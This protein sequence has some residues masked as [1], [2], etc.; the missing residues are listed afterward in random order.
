M[1]ESTTVD[2]ISGVSS[3][4]STVSPAL[5]STQYLEGC[6]ELESLTLRWYHTGT[7]AIQSSSVYT[8]HTQRLVQ[9]LG[10][11]FTHSLSGKRGGSK[12]LCN[13]NPRVGLIQKKRWPSLAPP[14][15]YLRI[16]SFVKWRGWAG[17]AVTGTA[18]GC[19]PALLLSLWL[20]PFVISGPAH[21]PC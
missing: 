16:S 14:S 17:S 1:P 7:I 19:N 5:S 20:C 10:G 4:Y 6:G 9:R 21:R 12:M 15:C 11:P 13:T 3:C 8:S 2:R 18:C